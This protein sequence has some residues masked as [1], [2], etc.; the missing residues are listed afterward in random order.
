M[1]ALLAL[2]SSGSFQVKAPTPI[3]G[4]GV[5]Q[6]IAARTMQ[7]EKQNSQYTM[8]PPPRSKYILG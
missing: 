1:T 2:T 4:S 5:S 3:P 8:Y 7:P 6:W